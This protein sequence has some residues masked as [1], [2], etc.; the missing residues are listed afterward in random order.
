MKMTKQIQLRW[1]FD[2]EKYDFISELQKAAK[3]EFSGQADMNT[4]LLCTQDDVFLYAKQHQLAKKLLGTYSPKRF[5][6]T[7]D[8]DYLLAENGKFV[9]YTQERGNRFP[10]T[11]FESESAADEWLLT[12]NNYSDEA[13]LE[14]IKRQFNW[15]IKK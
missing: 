3:R 2:S 10:I 1:M 8:G 12:Q 13:L 6:D 15:Y 4:E 7:H 5:D 9:L 11:S 14:H